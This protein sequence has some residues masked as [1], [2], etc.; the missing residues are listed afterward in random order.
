MLYINHW[1]IEM[2]KK[3]FQIIESV[4]IASKVHGKQVAIY[5][6]ILMDMMMIY[7]TNIE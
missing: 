4:A 6:F 3:N 2:L 1:S 5:K 7:I